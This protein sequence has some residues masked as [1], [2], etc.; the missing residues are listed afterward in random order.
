[1]K[2]FQSDTLY[3]EKAPL[4]K[5]SLVCPPQKAA[6]DTKGNA[7]NS[8]YVRECLWIKYVSGWWSFIRTEKCSVL[9]CRGGQNQR[10]ICNRVKIKISQWTG[11]GTFS[12]PHLPLCVWP[13]LTK[14]NAS[15]RNSVLSFI[16]AS[17]SSDSI[18]NSII[19]DNQLLLFCIWTCQFCFRWSTCNTHSVLSTDAAW[20]V[21]HFP[22]FSFTSDYHQ[23]LCYA[24]HTSSIVVFHSTV[25]KC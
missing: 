15:L 13:S 19:S 5:N 9:S 21:E 4:Q 8:Q 7:S 11:T 18:S 20:Y 16:S 10:N 12:I 24:F 6:G 2:C 17:C 22:T 3:L 23:R 14:P 25:F 1:M